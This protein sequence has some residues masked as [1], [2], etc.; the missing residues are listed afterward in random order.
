[1]SEIFVSFKQCRQIKQSREETVL[2]DIE[3]FDPQT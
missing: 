3:V 2:V 1:M